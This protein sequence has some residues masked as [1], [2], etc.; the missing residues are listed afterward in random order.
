MDLRM[1]EVADTLR[2]LLTAVAMTLALQSATVR[3]TVKT[4][5]IAS[6]ALRLVRALEGGPGD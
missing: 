3:R 4:Q 1:R 6:R 5:S 2:W